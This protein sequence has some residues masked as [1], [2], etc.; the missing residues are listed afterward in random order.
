SPQLG[1]LAPQA[2]ALAQDASGRV[3]PTEPTA[4]SPDLQEL[5]AMLLDV[6]ALRQTVDQLAVQIASSRQQIAGDLATLQA[7]QQAILRTIS[8]PPPRQAVPAHNAVQLTPSFPPEPV[9]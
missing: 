9:R 8:T 6:A 2:A 7:A 5:Q 1:W 3:A 4:P